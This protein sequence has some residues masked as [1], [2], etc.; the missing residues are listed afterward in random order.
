MSLATNTDAREGEARRL[1]DLAF[2]AVCAVA[3]VIA[4]APF[5]WL[6]GLALIRVAGIAGRVGWG[7]IL[8]RPELG[9]S[10]LG[11]LAVVA[12]GAAIGVPLG[13]LAGVFAAE[14]P[15]AGR[16]ARLGVDLLAAVPGVI[17]GLLVV[18]LVVLPMRQQSLLSGSL[19]LALVILPV[20][21]RGTEGVLGLVPATLR[22]AATSLGLP[23]WRVVAL[24]LLPAASRGVLAASLLAVGRAL[25]ETAP[26]LLTTFHDPR[27]TIGLFGAAPTLPVSIWRG[28]FHA[29]PEKSPWPLAL[30]LLTLAITLRAMALVLARGEERTR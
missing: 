24:A 5:V 3:F 27:A 25:G 15:K 19:A 18:V 8:A 22:D 20:V 7:A 14:S 26:L 16:L 21:A 13:I 2:R 28:A 11:S 4:M 23:R 17:V 30:L 29:S 6:L 1:R 9:A 12:L 10:L